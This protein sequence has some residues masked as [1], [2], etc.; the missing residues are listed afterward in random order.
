MMKLKPFYLFLIAV[1]PFF[2]AS[3][4]GKV[5]YEKIDHIDNEIWNVDSA[6]H[7]EMEITD[8]L[9]YYNLYINVRNT[10]AFET[11]YFYVFL[12][13]EF[14]NGYIGQDTLGCVLC[15]PYGKWTGKGV[16]R[17]KEN[18]FLF[19]PKVRFAQKGIYKFTVRQAMRE[20]NVKGISDFGM[21]LYNFDKDVI[22]VK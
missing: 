1:V 20:D 9:Q 13:S 7:Y 12:T 2:F 8:S 6:L 11:Q 18:H 10:V 17:L 21:S 5:F 16:G 3:C 14:P 4:N 15:D 19:K 22:K